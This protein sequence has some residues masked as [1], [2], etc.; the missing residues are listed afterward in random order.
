MITI[1][2]PSCLPRTPGV[3]GLE[4]RSGQKPSRNSVLAAIGGMTNDPNIVDLWSRTALKVWPERY[5]LVKLPARLV[6]DLSR[7]FSEV[8]GTFAMITANTTELSILVEE[9]LWSECDLRRLTIAV[10]GPYRVIT[11]DVTMELGIVGYLAPFLKCLS[12]GGVCVF[13]NCAFS[14]D[15]LIVQNEQLDD[16]I[17]ILDSF[18]KSCQM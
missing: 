2:E 12:E 4:P 13:A 5:S 3:S 8:H 1:G 15:H 18:I 10:D 14:N 9:S 16:A 6:L 7:L 11:L 17:E